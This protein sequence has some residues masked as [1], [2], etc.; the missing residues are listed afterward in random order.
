MNRNG[1]PRRGNIETR[2]LANGE[3]AF[4][5][6]FQARGRPQKVTLGHTPEWN[7]QRA[8]EELENI[9]AD[10]RRGAWRPHVPVKDKPVP[11]IGELADE[12]EDDAK[13]RGLR[14]SSLDALA[15]DLERLSALH[16]LAADEVTDKDIKRWV[17]RKTLERELLTSA[18]HKLNGG[19]QPKDLTKDE[20]AVIETYGRTARGLSPNMMRRALTK[21]AALLDL[22]RDEHDVPLTKNVA[23]NKRNW[24]L[25]DQKR[26]NHAEAPQLAALLEAAQAIEDRSRGTWR[27]DRPVL[28]GLLFLAGLRIS[29]VGALN[30]G[31]IDLDEGHI[32]VGVA[33]TFS[34]YRDVNIVPGLE[35]ALRAKLARPSGPSDAPLLVTAKGRRWNADNVRKTFAGVVEHA[36]RLLEERGEPP[37]PGEMSSHDGRRTFATMLA[38][39]GESPDYILTQLG[40]TSAAFTFSVYRQATSRRGRR[41]PRIREWFGEPGGK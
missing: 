20:R 15:L 38:L 16:P 21:L 23:R 39:N 17:Q 2:D 3:V 18:R 8:E 31:D 22:A 1:R 33:K 9:L 27:V 32:K 13:S 37:L 35:P 30:V 36:N 14:Q 7:R 4:V 28:I 29:E 12:Y 25:A 40:H 5:A 26:R 19:A 11:T 41:D 10:V 6:R 24:P 34:S